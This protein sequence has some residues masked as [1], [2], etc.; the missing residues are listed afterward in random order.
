MVQQLKSSEATEEA[1]GVKPVSQEYIGYG[2]DHSMSFYFKDIAGF[3]VD[4][5]SIA[6]TEKPRN[7]KSKLSA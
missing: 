1:N 7:G 4:G 6:G 2:D 5:A 3:T